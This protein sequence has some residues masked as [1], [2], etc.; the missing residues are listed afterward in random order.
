MPKILLTCTSPLCPDFDGDNGHDVAIDLNLDTSL[1]FYP[2]TP[3]IKNE[4][5]S[6]PMTSH[7]IIGTLIFNC[8]TSNIPNV[9]LYRTDP[10]GR[11]AILPLLDLIGYNH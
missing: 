4:S 3:R 5:S 8:P 2:G 9:K 10:I 11:A 7:R 1:L 6:D